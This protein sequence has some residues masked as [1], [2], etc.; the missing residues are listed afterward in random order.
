MWFRVEWSC[1]ERWH[2]SSRPCREGLVWVSG[3]RGA[4]FRSGSSMRWRKRSG[5]RGWALLSW[6]WRVVLA[7]QP[8]PAGPAVQI[9][10]PRGLACALRGVQQGMPAQRKKVG[11]RNG[12]D[13]WQANLPV[14]INKNIFTGIFFIALIVHVGQTAYFCPVVEPFLLL[15]CL[16]APSCLNVRRLH[17]SVR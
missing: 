15:V 5:K 7:L 1:V 11:R 16:G 12:Y 13:L 3:C 6:N 4:G 14:N 2:G 17:W 9:P 10:S 8:V